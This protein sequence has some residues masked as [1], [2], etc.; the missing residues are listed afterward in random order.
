MK[1]KYV[2]SLLVILFLGFLL[3]TS[4]NNESGL[5]FFNNTLTYKIKFDEVTS[6]GI[7]DTKTHPHG[8]CTGN[9]C[10]EV[11][12]GKEADITFSFIGALNSWYFT[13][14][15]ICQGSSKPG[16]CSLEVWQQ[17]EFEVIT[18]LAG[19]PNAQ[20]VVDLSSF[21]PQKF[22]LH[23][24]NRKAQNYF[25]IVKA[26]SNINGVEECHESDPP[27]VNKGKN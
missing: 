2:I 12:L 16:T 5:L 3:W 1:I 9:G 11:P 14:L 17:E 24:F 19:S 15:K 13:E 10:I 18:P 21:K 20:G 4:F 23:N 25:Y 6:A 7:L 8:Q 26:C 22:T 27:I